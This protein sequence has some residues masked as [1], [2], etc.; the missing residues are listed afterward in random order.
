MQVVGVRYRRT[1][2]SSADERGLDAYA[3]SNVYA[4]ASI[5]FDIEEPTIAFDEL[6]GD[7]VEDI[8]RFNGKIANAI[9][10]AR[11]SGSVILMTGGDCSHATGVVGGLQDAYGRDL[12]LGL[13]WFDA[14]GDFN[15]PAISQ[16][17]SL[18][19]MPVAVCAG[20]AHPSWRKGAHIRTPVPTSR[21]VLACTRNLDVNEK[22][23]I[24]TTDVAMAALADDFPGE[25]LTEAIERLSA[26][27][28][29]IYLHI[30]ADILDQSLI[31][32]H[33]N[34]EP[35]GPNIAQ[36]VAGIDS[37]LST[38]KVV[39]MALVSIYNTGG[40]GAVSVRSGI[41]L[42]RHGLESWQGYGT[43]ELPFA[44]SV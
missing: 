12:R 27:C 39:A 40:S 23:L 14:H 18:G 34:G 16:S 5:P 1:T 44:S 20:L 19:G 28:D 35:D 10:G 11:R 21:I 33:G 37:V 6:T 32:S 42:L 30:D 29:A 41:Q 22:A 38:G 2:P 36:T 26:E 9:A 43:A 8:G 13:V 4:S 17:G 31:P 25:P 24:R 15:T 7:A 3:G